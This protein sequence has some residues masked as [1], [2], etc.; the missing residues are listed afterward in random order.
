[1]TGEWLEELDTDEETY[2]ANLHR[3]GNL[4][5]AAKADNSKMSN[6]QWIYKNEV[7]KVISHLKM[8]MELIPIKKWALADIDCRTNELGE[9]LVKHIHKIQFKRL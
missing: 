6:L 9:R 1:M 7:L 2:K 5:L 3:L 8:N 4:A